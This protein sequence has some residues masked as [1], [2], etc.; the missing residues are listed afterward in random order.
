MFRRRLR[1]AFNVLHGRRRNLR[2][3]E[4]TLRD[5]LR[6]VFPREYRVYLM[7]VGYWLRRR[8]PWSCR[9]RMTKDV[10]VLTLYD[11]LLGNTG[12]WRRMEE[13]I[14]LRCGYVRNWR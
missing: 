3:R 6:L 9:R 10:G 13:R 14:R 4:D 5:V 7:R 12:R 1:F 8:R 2:R 11:E